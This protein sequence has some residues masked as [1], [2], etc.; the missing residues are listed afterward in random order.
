VDAGTFQ[1]W[2]SGLSNQGRWGESDER[3]TLNLIDPSVR[4]AAA[5]LVV[6][7]RSVSLAHPL[8][9][10]A[11]ADNSEPLEMEMQ[12]R[13]GAGNP[14][15]VERLS[16][17]YHG[18]AHTHLDALCHLAREGRLYNGFSAAEVTAQGCGKLAIPTAREGVFTRGL[19]VD[20]PRL[21]GVEWL[22]PGTAIYAADL[23][24]WEGEA[25]V[26]V[27]PGDALLV[28]TGRWALR[29]A[30]GPADASQSA[31]GLH[32]SAV[33]WLRERGVA[34]L[35]SEAAS[36]VL[37]SGVEGETHP[38]HTLALFSL[39]LPILDNLDL[40]AA[41]DEAARLGRWE[42]LLTLAPLVIP[43]GTGSPLN[44]IATF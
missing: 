37:P 1:E 4:I 12:L 28:R 27:R 17:V 30:Q 8:L 44:P 2:L 19:L 14:W 11:A 9:T 31:A 42:F 39:G 15:A 41:A 36:D 18:Y 21:R 29:A 5:K 22:E 38:V 10:A 33:S 16:L 40:D 26:R 23:E 34:L 24:A 32:A 7:G 20:L 35:G 25:G 43:G 13:P 6:E 3:G